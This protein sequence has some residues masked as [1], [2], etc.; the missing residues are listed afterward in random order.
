MIKTN[1]RIPN[2]T[3]EPTTPS[4]LIKKYNYILLL[5]TNCQI[6]L[7]TILKK[8]I[9]YLVLIGINK[10]IN[11]FM[12]F[13]IEIFK[14]MLRVRIIASLQNIYILARIWGEKKKF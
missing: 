10:Y 1:D 14:N 11:V 3:S 6:E 12:I 7:I 13:F 9:D 2:L 8:I 4:E 5:N